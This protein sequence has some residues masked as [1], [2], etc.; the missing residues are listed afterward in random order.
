MTTATRRRVLTLMALAT[1]LGALAGCRPA[2]A[3]IQPQPAWQGRRDV[4][5]F[6][7]ADTHIGARGMAA[8]NKAMIQGINALPGTAYPREIGGRVD[9]P[10][11]VLMPGDLTNSGAPAEWKKFVELFGHTGTEGLLRYPVY[12]GS[13]NHDRLTLGSRAVTAGVR[14]RHGALNYSWD[15]DDVHLVCLDLY[16]DAAASR[17]LAG[18]LAAVGPHRP[19][20]IF[21][22]H[23]FGKTVPGHSGWGDRPKRAFAKAVAGHNVVGVFHGHNHASMHHRW[24]G[25][26]VYNVGAP[27]SWYP[28]FQVVRITNATMAV[29]TWDWRAKLWSWRHVKK[30]RPPAGR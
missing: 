18:D 11:G 25:L 15:F 29:A 20:V 13:G 2:G 6:V 30:I 9:E 22:H 5:F 7:V 10:R 8:F 28:F 23:V 4:T 17:W 24:G 1:A 21:F 27:R 3:S 12:E 16:P 14:R 19:V 26:D